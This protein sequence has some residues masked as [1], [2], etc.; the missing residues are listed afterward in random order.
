MTR[1][2]SRTPRYFVRALFTL[3]A[4]AGIAYWL[5]IS[6]VLTA[7]K[8]GDT[9]GGADAEHW[10]YTAQFVL[11]ALGSMLGMIALALGFTAKARAYRVFLVVSLGCAL[12]W[13]AWVVGLGD[14]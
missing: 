12:A 13:I 1:H 4:S 3:A 7:I 9:C 8:C 6:S 11:A 5:L 14:F 2:Q 10:R